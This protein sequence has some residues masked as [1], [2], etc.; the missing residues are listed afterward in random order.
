MKM[1]LSLRVRENMPSLLCDQDRII[2][3]I[4]DPRYEG[5]FL[6]SARLREMLDAAVFLLDNLSDLDV[7]TQEMHMVLDASKVEV[8]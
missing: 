8:A 2:G 5:L 7:D 4:K 3:T 6:Q 1:E